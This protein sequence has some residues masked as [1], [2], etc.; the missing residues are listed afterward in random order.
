MKALVLTT[1]TRYV[2]VKDIPRPEPK[3]RQ[4]VIRVRAVA[5]NP[6]ETLFSVSPLAHQA[7]R[8]VGTDFAGEV[9]QVGAALVGED[10][11]RHKIG[12]RVAGFLQGGELL[13]N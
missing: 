4:V 2:S 13:N 10:D 3:D 6:V 12:A 7:T 8:V 1:K 11:P 5:L 9:V